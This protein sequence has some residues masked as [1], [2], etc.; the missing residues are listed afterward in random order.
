MS[1]SMTDSENILFGRTDDELLSQSFRYENSR[2]YSQLKAP[3]GVVDTGG[4]FGT[5]VVATGGAAGLANV[6]ANFRINS[7]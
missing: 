7:K 2:R 6:S 5:G 4:K 1:I 3:T